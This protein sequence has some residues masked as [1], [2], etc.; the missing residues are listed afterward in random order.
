M[1]RLICNYI[2]QILVTLL[3]SATLFEFYSFNRNKHNM[4]K[5]DKKEKTYQ[6]ITVVR[7]SF[8]I[9]IT[10]WITHKLIAYGSEVMAM[11]L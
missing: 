2:L 11:K 9:W 7:D 10:L 5:I 3:T 4:A 6:L 1:S 8:D